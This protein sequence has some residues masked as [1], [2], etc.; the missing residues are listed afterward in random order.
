MNN[1]LIIA[2][3]VIIWSAIL[4]RNI[5][6][7]NSAT[8]NNTIAV[9][10]DGTSSLVPSIY[11]FSITANHIWKTTKEVNKQLA[12]TLAAAQKV[13]DIYKIDATDIQ[14]QWVNINENRVYNNN[15]SQIEWYRGT[16]SLALTIRSIDDAGKMIDD[17]TAIDGLLVNGGS[18]DHD[19]D[20]SAV[21]L[22]RQAAFEDARTKAQTLADLAGMK[23]WKVISINEQ[24]LNNNYPIMYKSV[25]MMSDSAAPSTTINPGSEEVKIQLSLVFEL[26]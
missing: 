9:Q 2:A 16:H 7:L 24:I 6:S 12:T 1:T 5:S 21:A 22:A 10:G 17:L 18:Y 3:S 25:E 13:L 23:L 19:D 26:K 15:S 14:S 20:S 4:W 8:P 11:N